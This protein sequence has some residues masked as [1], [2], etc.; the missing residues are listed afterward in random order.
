MTPIICKDTPMSDEAGVPKARRL[1]SQAIRDFQLTIRDFF[2]EN[3]RSLPWRETSDPYEILVSEI[4]LQ[5]TQVERVAGKYGLFI[6]LFPDFKALA[7]AGLRDVLGAWQGLGYNRRAVALKRTALR[8]VTEFA[9]RLPECPETLRTLP[10]IGPATAGALMAFAF[11][12][13]AVFIET[14]IRRVF[15]HYFFAEAKQVRDQDILP[16]VQATLDIDQPRTWYYALMDYGAMLK[17]AEANPNRRSAHY[18]R[19]S[20]FQGSD[21]QIRGIIIRTMI[22]HPVLPVEA[23]VKTPG[24]D[25]ERVRAMLDRLIEEGFLIRSGEQVRIA[26]AMGHSEPK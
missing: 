12:K 23:I 2:R 11:N 26:T 14:N 9:G 25:P 20:R 4:M 10:G 1:T 24:T 8:V 16:L 18:S 15:I 5:Q 3:G 13:P 19:Q 17:S 21:R 22:D 7:V 6:E